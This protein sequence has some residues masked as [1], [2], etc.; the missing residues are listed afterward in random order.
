MKDRIVLIR[1]HL[2]IQVIIGSLVLGLGCMA[3]GCGAKSAS[4]AAPAKVPDSAKSLQEYMKKQ[5]AMKKHAPGKPQPG[6]P[7]RR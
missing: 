4:D 6:G 5:T 7:S 2:L 3:G 1:P